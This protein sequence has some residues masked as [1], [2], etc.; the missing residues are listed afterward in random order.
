MKSG[1]NLEQ[2]AAEIMRQSKAKEDYII[3]TQNLSFE[4]CG[5]QLLMRVVGDN[6]FD[7]IEPLD[8]RQI[9]HRQIGTHLSIPA[10]YYDR[11][12]ESYPE[13]LAQNV[14]AWLHREPSQRMLRTLDGSARAF[15]SNRYRRLDN[16][17]I[18]EAILPIIGE[19]QGARFES[20]Q[21]TESRMYLKVVNTRLEAEVTPG[22][23]VQAG[24]IISNSE[25]GLGAVCIQPLVFRL[26]CSNGMVVNDAQTR[27][28]HVGRVNSSDE[29]FLLYSDK[30][31]EADDLAFFL[32]IQDTVKAVVEEAKF[33]TVVNQMREA[34]GVRLN[35]ADVPGVVKLA[36]REFG[37]SDR[38][39]E[40]VLQ[41]LIEGN[42]LTLYGLSNAITRH[43]QDL[44][45][46]DRATDLEGIGYNI[47]T[48]PRQQWS[49]I[50]QVA[51]AA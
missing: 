1:L 7:R 28:N 12:L 50:N 9:A 40:G 42:D 39:S 15:L 26:V 48:M 14:N 22:D 24:M 36:S 38:E 23:I 31:I 35:T 34:T 5:D 3:N 6:G 46:Y 8:I 32:K 13:L 30:T 47:L 11:M 43:S 33:A 4:P 44:E 27:R 51:M 16:L 25:T 20:C 18:A 21:I 19:M 29:N 41:Y 45:D 37:I 17:E 10:K 49:K 2:M